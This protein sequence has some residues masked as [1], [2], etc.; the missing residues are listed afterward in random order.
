MVVVRINNFDM[1]DAGFAGLGFHSSSSVSNGILFRLL[2]DRNYS[3]TI[4]VVAKDDSG[5]KRTNFFSY[6]H[7]N[8]GTIIRI[9]HLYSTII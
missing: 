3:H 2:P 7:N 5:Q 4:F 8:L 9:A 1:S 6:I